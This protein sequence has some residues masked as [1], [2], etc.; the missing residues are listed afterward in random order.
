M[1]CTTASSSNS[2]P[3]PSSCN[4]R[5]S[6]NE[7]IRA[8]AAASLEQVRRSLLLAVAELRAFAELLYPPLLDDQGLGAALIAAAAHAGVPAHVELPLDRSERAEV[9]LTVYLCCVRALAGSECSSLVA[10][11]EDDVLRFEVVAADERVVAE[12][13]SSLTDRVHALG[14]QLVSEGSRIT[15]SLPV[16]P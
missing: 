1:P 11:R 3:L 9:A 14:G 6:S 10:R 8:A 4:S 7:R 5:C 15:G 13:A 12:V 2:S 16:G